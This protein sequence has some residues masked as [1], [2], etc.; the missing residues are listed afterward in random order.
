MPAMHLWQVFCDLET[1]EYEVLGQAS[2]DADLIAKGDF[3][4]SHTPKPR[5][6]VRVHSPL[7]EQTTLAALHQEMRATGL[8]ESPGAMQRRLKE[9]GWAGSS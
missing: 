5:R 3:I 8:R 7:V 2:D 4:N 1:R 9:L 6:Q